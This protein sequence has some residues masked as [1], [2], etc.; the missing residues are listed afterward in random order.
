[1]ELPCVTLSFFSFWFFHGPRRF[2]ARKIIFDTLRVVSLG[3]SL[4]CEVTL[5]LDGFFLLV[6]T[7]LGRYFLFVL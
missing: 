3:A 2:V 4:V 1:M 7:I 6:S 5:R